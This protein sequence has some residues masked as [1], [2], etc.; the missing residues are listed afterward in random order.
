MPRQYS[1][2][3][4]HKGRVNLGFLDNL[5]FTEINTMASPHVAGTAAL[6][7]SSNPKA[8]PAQVLA[9][10]KENKNANYKLSLN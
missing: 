10:L 6:Y 3:L 9:A 7:L 4:C 1:Q 2:Y 5:A 8:T